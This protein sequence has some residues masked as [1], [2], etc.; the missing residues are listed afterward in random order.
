MRKIIT[1]LAILAGFGTG[2][3]AQVTGFK[4]VY[5]KNQYLANPAMAGIEKGLN[6]N[7]GY[8]RQL[9]SIPGGPRLQT[10]TA[11]YAIGNNAGV[12]L[13]VNSDKAGLINHTRAMG[14]FAYHLPLSA[15]GSKLNFGISLGV[16]GVNIN[17]QAI[18]GDQ[19]D[20]E[21]QDLNNRRMYVDGDFGAS[22]TSNSWTVQ[23]S[24]PNLKSV[25]TKEEQQ[26]LSYDRATYFAAIGYKIPFKSYSN[27]HVEPKL[28]YRGMKGYDSIVDLGVNLDLTSYNF[29][30]MALYHTNKSMTVGGGFKLLDTN[31]LFAYTTNGGQMGSFVNNSFE[32]G[33][34]LN[35][36]NK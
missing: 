2:A 11:D 27:G 17:N 6:L 35:L 12:G 25:F 33:V 31:L 9:T 28:A 22:Y 1:L 21:A 19:G 10:L 36:F 26:N 13:N 14:T 24:L 30:L 15:E 20:T 23:G 34:K 8:Q 7:I 4:S 32:F 5:F 29:N 16:S 3:N 18:I